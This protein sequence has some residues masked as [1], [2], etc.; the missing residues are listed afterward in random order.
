MSQRLPSN[1]WVPRISTLVLRPATGMPGMGHTKI[2]DLVRTCCGSPTGIRRARLS[3]VWTWRVVYRRGFSCRGA[4]R[5][6]R[7]FSQPVPWRRQMYRG[8]LDGR[9]VDLHLLLDQRPSGNCRH[10]RA[11][12]VCN[13]LSVSCT[14]TLLPQS[15]SS[16]LQPRCSGESPALHQRGA[17]CV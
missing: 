11:L 2:P 6:Q 16:A 14:S 15:D 13:R 5:A 10:T 3:D 9:A 7:R 12:C 4:V 1:L 8:V 17:L